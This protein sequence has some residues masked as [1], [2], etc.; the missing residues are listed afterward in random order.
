MEPRSVWKRPWPGPSGQDWVADLGELEIALKDV[1]HELDHG[2]LNEKPGLENPT[3]DGF[4]YFRDRLVGRYPGAVARR[5]LAPDHRRALQPQP[6]AVPPSDFGAPRA[7][8]PAQPC[9]SSALRR[10]ALLGLAF[11]LR[12]RRRRRPRWR[13]RCT[14]TPVPTTAPAVPTAA[15]ARHPVRLKAARIT[16]RAARRMGRALDS[17]AG[18]EP[19]SIRAAHACGVSSDC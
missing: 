8:R 15:T 11:L 7:R 17:R 10:S 4:A 1:A 6:L 18:G 16:T 3:L 13:R 9:S 12:G 5:G 19:S 2:L 14:A